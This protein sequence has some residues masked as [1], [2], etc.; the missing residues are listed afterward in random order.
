[1]TSDI[2]IDVLKMYPRIDAL[3]AVCPDGKYNP[4]QGVAI[5]RVRDSLDIPAVG[6]SVEVETT[7]KV[8]VG[9]TVTHAV[10][11]KGEAGTGGRFSVCGAEKSQPIVFRATRGDAHGEAAIERWNTD[12]MVLSITVRPRAP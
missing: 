2:D 6:A 5:V 11:R 9:D 3:R 12:V 7:Q 8:V 4:D 1:P 10:V